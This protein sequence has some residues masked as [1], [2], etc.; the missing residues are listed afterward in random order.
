LQARFGITTPRSEF[1]AKVK[2]RR[3]QIHERIAEFLDSEQLGKWPWRD[4]V[5]AALLGRHL[6]LELV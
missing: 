1:V 3:G 4:P 6:R 2:E 5:R